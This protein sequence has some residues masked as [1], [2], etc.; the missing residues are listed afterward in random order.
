M[1]VD[2]INPH[3]EI[4]EARSNI[5]AKFDLSYWRHCEREIRQ[6]EL[7]GVAMP[8]KY[9]KAALTPLG[10]APALSDVVERELKLPGSY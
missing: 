6:G 7:L 8:R 9:G 1:P 10:Q 2:F 5:C 4:R 3:T